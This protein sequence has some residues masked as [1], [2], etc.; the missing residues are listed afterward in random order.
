MISVTRDVWHPFLAW[1]LPYCKQT[2][3]PSYAC[4]GHT[5]CALAAGLAFRDWP[6]RAASNDAVDYDRTD[7]FTLT[8]RSAPQAP[9]ATWEKGTQVFGRRGRRSAVYIVRN[10]VAGPKAATRI[11]SRMP[12]ARPEECFCGRW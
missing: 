12:W 3:A 1:K 7:R 10:P 5:R 4:A 11:I 6:K 9:S 8:G 2:P